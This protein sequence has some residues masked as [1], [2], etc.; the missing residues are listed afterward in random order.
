M[1]LR[2]AVVFPCGNPIPDSTVYTDVP[3]L[4][5]R[6]PSDRA[7]AASLRSGILIPTKL[8]GDLNGRNEV[9]K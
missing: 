2:Q 1:I 3:A 6:D 5:K 8:V 4:Y 7:C 9:V